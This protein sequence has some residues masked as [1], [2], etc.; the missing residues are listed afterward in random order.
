MVISCLQIEQCL[1]DIFHCSK[2]FH[3]EGADKSL[4]RL[5]GDI[6]ASLGATAKELS[7]ALARSVAPLYLQCQSLRAR[8]WQVTVD[9]IHLNLTVSIIWLAEAVPYNWWESCGLTEAGEHAL[10]NA[11]PHH[12]FTSR[13]FAFSEDEKQEADDE[14]T[15]QGLWERLNELVNRVR[16]IDPA[17]GS[18]AFLV[19]MLLVLDDLQLRCD[20]ALGNVQTAYERRKRILQDQ[21]YG[22]DVM[23]WAV[24]VAELRLWLQ[25]VVETELEPAELHFRP[26]LPNLNFKL[27]PG[28]SLLQTVGDLDLSPFRRSELPLPRHLK[29]KLTKLK[30]KKRRFFQGEEPRLMEPLLK[31]EELDLF[32]EILDHKLHELGQQIQ[33]KRWQLEQIGVQTKMFETAPSAAERKERE[34]LEE[35]IRHLK[36]ERQRLQAAV[37]ALRPDQPPPFVWDLAFV[38]IFEDENPGFDI[39]IGNPPYVRQ[40]KIRDYLD[41]FN[42]SEYLKRLNE[43]LRAINPGFMDKDRRISGR[44]DYYLYFYLHAL[45]LLADKGSFCFITS[46]SWL[47]AWALWQ[48]GLGE[49][50]RGQLLDARQYEGN[51]WGGKYL[52]APDIYFTILEKAQ[53]YRVCLHGKDPKIVE[54]M[55]DMLED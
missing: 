44:A 41:R 5:T 43:G 53:R 55:T 38:E 4:Y 18:G 46:N 54:D 11:L 27:R 45:S 12:C 51:K 16:I 9:K 31:K 22:V 36:S 24:R 37:S 17:C 25:L 21:L 34:K 48:E 39:V 28:D 32:R 20:A 33:N 23:E 26:L 13:V 2:I 29:G 49:D 40:E 6:Y 19:G 47:D 30:G 15:R 50:E 35:E 1:S 10:E 52:R 42:R 7:D 14:V 8:K 3:S